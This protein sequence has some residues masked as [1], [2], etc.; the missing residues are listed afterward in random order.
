MEGNAVKWLVFAGIAA[1]SIWAMIL[2]NS[3]DFTLTQSVLLLMAFASAA[4]PSR[5]LSLILSEAFCAGFTVGFAW[6][7]FMTDVP[8]DIKVRVGWDLM[9]AMC[10]MALFER[11]GRRQP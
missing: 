8:E 11:L 1:L 10:L 6:F 7:L 5:L 9:P 3:V 4:S 2:S